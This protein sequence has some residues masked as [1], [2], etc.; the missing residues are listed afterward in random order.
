[1]ATFPDKYSSSKSYYPQKAD[2]A[3]LSKSVQT[4][5]QESISDWKMAVNYVEACNCDFGCPCNFSGTPTY[6][7]CR[8]LVFLKITKGNYGDVPLDGLAIVYVGSWPKAIHE[9][10]GTLQIFVSK[11]ANQK[12]RDAITKIVHGKAKG[13]GFFAIF[14]TTMKYVLEPQFVD[15]KYKIDGKNSSFSVPGVLDAQLESFKNPMTGEESE[16]QINLPKGFIWQTA[17]ACK[18]KVMRIVSPNLT[19]DDSGQNAFFCESLTFKGP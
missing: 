9:G 5:R 1:M 17:R 11:E 12:Q 18:T 7:F 3:H 6:G 13:N 8:A 16:T 19:F 10:T 15:V 14:A 4:S 2:A